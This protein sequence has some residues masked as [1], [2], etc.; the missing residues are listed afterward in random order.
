VSDGLSDLVSPAELRE[1]LSALDLGGGVESVA[2]SAAGGRVLADSVRADLDV[3][4]FDRAAMDGYAVRAEDTHGASETA[5]VS[6]DVAGSVVAGE[7]PDARVESG[8]AVTITTGAVVPDGADAVV[9]VEA[10]SERQ[11]DGQTVVRVGQAV[12]PGENVTPAGADVAAGQHALAPGTRLTPRTV[13]LLAALGRET[14]LVRDRPR[15]AIFST[16]AE[17]VAPGD[18]LDHAAG[19]IH[20]VNTHTVATAVA[21]AGC[22]PVV[23]D[24]VDDDRGALRAALVEAAAD[25]DLVV[26]SGASSA[27]V[28]DIIADIV[29]DNGQVFLHG[30]AVKPGKPT[31]V[32]EI[33]G[34][35]YVG[36]PGYPV[37]ALSVFRTFVTPVLREAAARP[38][39]ATETATARLA[40]AERYEGDRHRLVPVG[41]VADGA[42]EL[43]AYPVD[44]GSGATTSLAYADGIVEMPAETN[45]LDSGE[46]VLVERFHGDRPP[47]VLLV[48]ESDPRVIDALEAVDR[49]RSLAGGTAGGER[50]LRDGIADVGVVTGRVDVGIELASW[51]REWGLVVPAGEGDSTVADVLDGA[52]TIGVLGTETGLR[53]AFDDALATRADELRDTLAAGREIGERTVELAGIESPARRVAAGRLDAGL[54]VATTADEFGLGFVSMGHQ[55]VAVRARSDRT[56]K[57]GVQR[58][59]AALSAIGSDD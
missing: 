56:G 37:S 44:K 41:L 36:L 32:G 49:A 20:D 16:G 10:T 15:V 22:E 31:I 39:R 34:T 55:R 46:E 43:L 7:R 2:L 45:V 5:P 40:L 18:P 1:T 28:T 57:A 26:T 33:E 48:G 11:R 25:C 9:M 8:Q 19:Q 21:N 50:W 4:G 29:A 52:E 6:L 51:D 54:G 14:V 24:A 30:V 59:R 58:L 23:S 35:P 3:P 38:E 17:L 42:G 13:G 53:R 47:A 27:G 12:T